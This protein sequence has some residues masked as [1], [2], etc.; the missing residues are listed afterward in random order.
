[1]AD[2][3]GK[4]IGQIP[5]ALNEAIVTPL[6]DEVGKALELGGQSVGL[7]PSPIKD[8][9]EEAKRKVEEEKKKQNI[10]VFLQQYQADQQ[11]LQAQKQQLEKEKMQK[12][13]EEKQK[14]QI[15]QFETFEKNKKSSEINPQ[16]QGRPEI[17]LGKG[18]G[19]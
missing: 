7:I 6:K 3:V 16:G 18:V 9:A 10:K 15:K 19:G 5:Q 11:R 4:A 1:M 8:P 12:P 14:K 13:E 2:G 17:K